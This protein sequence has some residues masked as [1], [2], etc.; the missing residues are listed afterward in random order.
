MGLVCEQLL[1]RTRVNVRCSDVSGVVYTGG[2]TGWQV[3]CTEGSEHFD[4]VVL[5]NHDT[6]MAACAIEQALVA[7]KDPELEQPSVHAMLSKFTADLRALDQQ[8]SRSRCVSLG[9]C[10]SGAPVSSTRCICC[11]AQWS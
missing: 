11:I 8:A 1:H 2:A 7:S 9:G 10:C 4:G 3:Q 6:Q 5:A